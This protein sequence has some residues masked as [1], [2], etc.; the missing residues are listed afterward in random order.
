MG[1]P[2]LQPALLGGL[3]AGIL[4]ALPFVNLANCCCVWVIAGGVIAAYVMQQN[5]PLPVTA[6]DGAMVG[7]LAGIIG[8]IVAAAVSIPIHFLLSPLMPGLYDGNL[9]TFRHRRDFPPEVRDMMKGISPWVFAFIGGLIFFLIELVF[10]T[11][12]GLF[13]A[14]MFSK[15]APPPPPGPPPPTHPPII[16][17][18]GPPVESWSYPD[19]NS[20]S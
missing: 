17:P 2:K 18:A 6:G 14:L 15:P 20:Q 16:P 11:L 5:Y 13:G 4:S 1:A 10:S 19:Q 12:G 7:F 9:S 8:A 3:F